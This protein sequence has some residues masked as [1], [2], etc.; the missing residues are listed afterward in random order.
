MCHLL[1][2]YVE[3]IIIS[4]LDNY[5]NVRKH[6]RELQV[7][8]FEKK[9]YKEIGLAFSKSAKKHH[10]TVQTCYEKENLTNYGFI[11]EECL[12][13]SLAWKLTG[14]KF[15]K[16]KARNCHCVEMVDIGSYNS[17]KHLCKYCYANYDEEKVENNFQEHDDNSSLLVGFLKKDDIIKIRK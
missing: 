14:K 4:F 7:K 11:Q 5:K 12:S 15:P 17:C 2:G 8:E 3:H 1:D 16:W 13:S 9:D 6:Q 10:M